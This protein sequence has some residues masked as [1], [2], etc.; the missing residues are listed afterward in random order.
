[1]LLLIWSKEGNVREEVI[2]A[3]IQLY[4]M[5]PGNLSKNSKSLY[6]A[7]NLI[8]SANQIWLGAYPSNYMNQLGA[9]GEFGR[10]DIS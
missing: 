10:V 4:I 7:K 8:R 5:P 2:T 9:G 3:Y 6:T 1:M